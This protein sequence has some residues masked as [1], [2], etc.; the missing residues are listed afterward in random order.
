MS[1]E[2]WSSIKM[3][4]QHSGIPL[5]VSTWKKLSAHDYVE[6]GG[7]EYTYMRDGSPMSI[8]IHGTKFID[9]PITSL[10]GHI[11]LLVECKYREPNRAW[12]FFKFD[13]GIFLYSK[14]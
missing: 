11:D 14:I 2:K 6:I 3:N 7:G 1:K 13:K 8:D 9:T 10:Q 4:L 12:Y 5:E